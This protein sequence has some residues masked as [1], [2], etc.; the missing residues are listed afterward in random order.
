MYGKFASGA[1]SRF[2]WMAIS[3][4]LFKVHAVSE[5]E[6]KIVGRSFCLLSHG[7]TLDGGNDTHT[8]YIITVNNDESDNMMNASCFAADS[9]F[10]ITGQ[11]LAVEAEKKG[12]QEF[13]YQR[14][15]HERGPRTWQ[16]GIVVFP[17]ISRVL[18][19]LSEYDNCR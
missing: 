4:V 8:A 10:Y 16:F 1:L 5:R 2:V 7:T 19:C 17:L 13:Y 11:R 18:P 12:Q 6:Q 3:P 15:R 9:R 14:E